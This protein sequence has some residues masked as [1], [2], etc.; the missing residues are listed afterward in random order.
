MILLAALRTSAPLPPRPDRYLPSGTGPRED[1]AWCILPIPPAPV[2]FHLCVIDVGAINLCELK[3]G[4]GHAIRSWTAFTP[5]Q[6][7]E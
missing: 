1:M 4:T 2:I 5:V 7:L 3:E 6:G